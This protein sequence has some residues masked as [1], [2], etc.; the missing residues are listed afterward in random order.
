MAAACLSWMMI[1]WH[2]IDISLDHC[3]DALTAY[4]WLRM[5]QRETKEILICSCS[6][7]TRSSVGGGIPTWWFSIAETRP[8]CRHLNMLSETTIGCPFEPPQKGKSTAV[9]A[10]VVWL[11]NDRTKTWFIESVS[12]SVWR[13]QFHL[14]YASG[15]K[16]TVR[17]CACHN[18][19]A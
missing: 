12:M 7:N 16:R 6:N 15:Q 3:R 14:C 10:I 5:R 2:S 1:W 4:W 13:L 17:T 19:D 18:N 8:E 11:L 9:V